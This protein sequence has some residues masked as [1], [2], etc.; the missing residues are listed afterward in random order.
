MTLA[1]SDLERPPP[2]ERHWRG[3]GE[4]R[5]NR[6]RAGTNQWNEYGAKMLEE[7]EKHGG[8]FDRLAVAGWQRLQYG[9][10]DDP[11]ELRRFVVL[12]S[13]SGRGPPRRASPAAP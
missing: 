3:F 6:G 7:P 11:L 5:F 12:R 2:R 8:L 4:A 10:I 1:V 9:I 13:R